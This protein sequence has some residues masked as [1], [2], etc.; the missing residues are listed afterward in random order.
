MLRT[1]VTSSA[2]I[3]LAV[4]AFGSA[5]ASAQEEEARTCNP[6]VDSAGNPV[7]EAEGDGVVTH[8]GSYDCPPEPEVAV[9]A[10]PPAPEPAA[11]PPPP[12][13]PDQGIVY[14]PFDVAALTPDA[15]Q[16]IDTIATDIRDRELGGITVV[17]HTDTAGSLD[18]NQ[19]LSEQ[20]AQ[21]V[22]AQ[23]IRQGIPA[24][25]VE[26]TG[27]G[28]SNPAVDTPDGT[29]LQANRRATINFSS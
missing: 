22:A 10:E 23:L 19:Q 16:T 12:P 1:F 5:P 26:A 14:F 15:E 27:V 17:G 28:E 11:P 21:N 18:Y 6:V 3:A 9:V 25:V 7:V 24:T 4:V 29:P 13:L 8:L 2:A 20:R